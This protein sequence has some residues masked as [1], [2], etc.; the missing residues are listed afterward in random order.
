VSIQNGDADQGL[1]MIPLGNDE[2]WTPSV[3]AAHHYEVHEDSFGMEQ[4]F[5]SGDPYHVSYSVSCETSMA[6]CETQHPGLLCDVLPSAATASSAEALSFEDAFDGDVSIQGPRLPHGRGGGEGLEWK[7]PHRMHLQRREPQRS[8]RW[9][10][11]A[12]RRKGGRGAGSRKPPSRSRTTRCTTRGRDRRTERSAP[13][14]T[15]PRELRSDV[16]R[17]PRASRTRR[18]QG[19]SSPGPGR[20]H[21]SGSTRWPPPPPRRAPSPQPTRLRC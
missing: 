8:K 11:R 1:V 19:E 5:L 13:C 20:R 2:F 4:I 16:L 14:R 21:R 9:P 15:S 17:S 18:C 3:S 6:A 12:E 7:R 10:P